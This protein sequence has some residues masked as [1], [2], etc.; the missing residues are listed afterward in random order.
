MPKLGLSTGL[1][2]SGLTTPGIVTDSL[3]LKHNY[4][5][6]NV[7]PISDGA[8]YFDGSNDYINCGT[9]IN[10]GTADFT[11]AG[12]IKQPEATNNLAIISKFEDND[13][14]W[15]IR[16][17]ASDKLHFYVLVGGSQII[18]LVSTNTLPEDTWVHIAITAN[19]SGNVQKAY[20]NGVLD[21]T[22]TNTDNSTD[23]D[24]DADLNIGAYGTTNFFGGN[25]CNMAI[26][27]AVLTQPE[28]KSVMNKNY[29]GL[30]SSEKTSL[31]SW[32]NLSADANDSHG[33]NNGTLS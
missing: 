1:T 17:D 3:V 25:V 31:Q 14:R 24:I 18:T 26:W 28:I 13:N 20:I 21:K 16:S 15:Y 6:G 22:N 32:W 33:S 30:T 5:A 23:F 8:A 2:R 19:R 7:I 10:L 4:T 11:I 29:A 9:G 27:S 12:W